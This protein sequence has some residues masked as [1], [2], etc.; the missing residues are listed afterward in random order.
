MP[1]HQN[2][3]KFS[4]SEHSSYWKIIYKYSNPFFFK[5]RSFDILIR[6]GS[7][8]RWIVCWCRRANF[9]KSFFI[10]IFWELRCIALLSEFISFPCLFSKNSLL[11]FRCIWD[12]SVA[13]GKFALWYWTFWKLLIY[14]LEWCLFWYVLLLLIWFCLKI[15]WRFIGLV[16]LPFES[17]LFCLGK[18][19]FE[20]WWLVC[21]S[22]R[23]P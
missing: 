11:A 10:S 3:T 14:I 12:I 21:L 19:I 15:T 5:I 22:L 4:F 23:Y 2:L 8:I 20:S 13:L 9:F 17:I 6:R 7:R 16:K 1:R 18:L